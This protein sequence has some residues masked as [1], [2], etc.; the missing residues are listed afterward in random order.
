M[1]GMTYGTLPTLHEFQRAFDTADL[2]GSRYEVRAG[3]SGLFA[4]TKFA[5][6]WGEVESF[7]SLGLY[8]LLEQLVAAWEAGRD[9][10]GDEASSALETLG[11]E[12]I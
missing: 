10:A 1:R 12:W 4:G 8:T 2:R 11:F 7:T 6:A 9:E 3:L 5:L